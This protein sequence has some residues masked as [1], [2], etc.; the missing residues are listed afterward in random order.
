MV[1]HRPSCLLLYWRWDLEEWSLK[2]RQTKCSSLLYSED[3]TFCTEVLMW[4]S[5]IFFIETCVSV[6]VGHQ[7]W[8]QVLFSPSGCPG[9]LEL[10]SRLG[11]ALGWGLQD[12]SLVGKW[13]PRWGWRFGGVLQGFQCYRSFRAFSSNIQW[14]TLC[15]YA[16]FMVNKSYVWISESG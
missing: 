10:E 11:R 14:N 13:V 16:L 1:L 6:F 15:A 9:N 4:Q 3:Q 8:F 2:R 7:L 5:H 12:P